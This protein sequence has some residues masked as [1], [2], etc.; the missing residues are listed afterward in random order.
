MA[1]KVTMRGE[2][3]FPSEYLCAEDL[4][5][6]GRDV[7]LTI[8]N[9]EKTKVRM[10]DGGD[11]EKWVVHFEKTSKKLI[12]NRKSHPDAIAAMYGTKAEDWL[13]K[14]ITLYPA[15]V[16]AFGEMVDAV[17]IRDKKPDDNGEHRPPMEPADDAFVDEVTA[18]MPE[19]T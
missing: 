16:M 17:R 5:A 19:D 1:G 12:L 13:G 14:R 7:T 8:R 10:K 3:M 11:E 2:V 18:G 6:A 15:R 4:L 9:I